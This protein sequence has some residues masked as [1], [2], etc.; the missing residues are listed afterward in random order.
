MRSQ[1]QSELDCE[2]LSVETAQGRESASADTVLKPAEV[3]PEARNRSPQSQVV[4]RRAQVRSQA[5]LA[6]TSMVCSLMMTLSLLMVVTNLQKKSIG[7]ANT[8]SRYVTI[9]SLVDFKTFYIDQSQYIKTIDK[10]KVGDHYISSKPATLPVIA[11]GIYW[12]YQRLTGKTLA[13]N[14]A[15]VVRVIGFSTSGVGHILFMLYFY[16]LCRLLFRRQVAVTFALAGACFGYLGVGYATHINELSTSAALAIC[17]L[18]YAV[19]IR[20]GRNPKPWHWPFTGFVLG[21]LPAINLPAAAISGLIGLYLF[22]HDRRK[23]L[24]WFLPALMPGLI[25]HLA[26]TYHI[27]GSFKPF[28]FNSELKNF[29]EF[30]FR[31]TAAAGAPPESKIT[32][33]FN[34][35][36]GHHGLFSMTPLCIFGLY[37]LVRSL[38][39]RRLFAESVVVAASVATFLIFF[40]WRTRNYGGAC[41][42]MRWYVPVM[43]L[44]LLYFG[45]W[46]DR[47][48]L[49]RA[50]WG[51]TLL[52]FSISF[53]NVQDALGGP[54]RRSLWQNWLSGP[55]PR[56]DKPP[57]S[58]KAESPA[59]APGASPRS[60]AP[61]V[62]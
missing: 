30:H 57:Q 60:P 49:T 62:R 26:L 27:S 29:K 53:F 34:T 47:V 37:E 50:L 24:L 28:Y 31:R 36:L 20:H 51:L 21:L 33:A 25:V 17:G 4:A 22:G 44:L 3:E 18:Y 48:R 6:F 19:R 52:A 43:P 59:S 35:L 38:K 1:S 58:P 61:T 55:P 46:L 16:R 14:E 11:A 2:E 15:E 10:Y 23:T 12:I 45:L 13:S 39:A 41:V 8:G 42:G 7:N 9:E 40:I 32:Y 56:V 5:R 54:Y